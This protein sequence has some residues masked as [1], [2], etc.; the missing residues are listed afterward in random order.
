MDGK[1]EM[2]AVS[3]DVACVVLCNVCVCVCGGC[4]YV[5][6]AA[7]EVEVEVVV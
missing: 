2:M 1:V 3:L 7:A 5:V 4:S 6:V